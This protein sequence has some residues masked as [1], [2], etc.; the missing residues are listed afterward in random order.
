MRIYRSLVHH[1]DRDRKETDSVMSNRWLLG[2]GL[3]L[4][5]LL[6]A[7]VIIVLLESEG[8]FDPGTPEWTVQ[9]HLKASEDADFG[10]SYALLSAEL[11]EECTASDYARDNLRADNRV[12]DTRVVLRSTR[13]ID[14][15]TEV[16][17]Q[18]TQIYRGDFFGP[19]ESSYDQSF[20]LRQEDGAW[21]FV[22]YPWPFSQ[23]RTQGGSDII[24]PPLPSP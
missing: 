11:R 7:S 4:A 16:R 13:V 2:G 14:G 17:A 10:A 1:I 21:K 9:A 6:I 23:C 5:G 20:L 12:Q 15:S 18:I 3:F 8:S 22:T 24:K 19:E